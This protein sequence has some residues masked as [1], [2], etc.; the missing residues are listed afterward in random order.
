MTL[1]QLKQSYIKN[2]QQEIPKDMNLMG[3]VSAE[4]VYRIL[5][6]CHFLGK[7]DD[8]TLYYIFFYNNVIFFN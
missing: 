1:D 5:E 6:L 3:I 8:K 4:I 7:K 2:S